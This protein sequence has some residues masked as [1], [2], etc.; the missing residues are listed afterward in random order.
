[1]VVAGVLEYWREYGSVWDHQDAAQCSTAERCCQGAKNRTTCAQCAA[2]SR[3]QCSPGQ[4]P[5]YTLTLTALSS[6][7]PVDLARAPDA[8]LLSSLWRS[9]LPWSVTGGSR[10]PRAGLTI[11][12]VQCA[13]SCVQ[14]SVQVRGS[15]PVN[16]N[17]VTAAAA[18]A[19]TSTDNPSSPSCA[20]PRAVH[21]VYLG[22]AGEGQS[23]TV[24]N[25]QAQRLKPARDPNPKPG[26]SL[27]EAITAT[28][29]RSIP[30]VVPKHRVVC[31]LCLVL[32]TARYECMWR[33]PP[34]HTRTRL[35]FDLT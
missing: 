31:V 10:L 19:A 17:G 28:A 33:G 15:A 23:C 29:S 2:C 34:P 16:C 20:F 1:M 22:G 21:A 25:K 35:A 11:S 26:A 6:R 3:V 32:L 18:A 5:L 13:V 7:D 24:Q 30:S 14:C 8:P 27:G 12:C 9:P 4:V